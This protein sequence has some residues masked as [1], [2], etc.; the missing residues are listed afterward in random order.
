MK[1]SQLVAISSALLL[2]LA[3]C[4]STQ[5]PANSGASD[6][7][8]TQQTTQK[9]EEPSAVVAIKPSPDKYTWHMKNYVGMNASAVGHAS[10]GGQ[11][12]DRYGAGVIKIVFVTKDGT[13]IAIDDDEA[14]KQYK[15][16]AQSYE[17]NTEIKYTFQTNSEGE[18]YDSLVDFQ[19]I[20]E[21]VLS[22][23][24]VGENGNKADSTLIQIAPDKYA[25]YVRDYVGRN[26]S[27]CGY[28][29]LGGSIVDSY[30]AGYVT[31][32]LI[33]DDGA[34]IDLDDANSIARYK[35]TGQDVAPNSAIT[36]EFLKDSDGNEYSNLVDH[37][38]IQ[39]ISL[40]LTPVDA[41]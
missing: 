22:V 35:V 24:K 34:A 33:P 21:I 32:S 10:L 1:K 17:P 13:H 11:R 12:M 29:S 4:G 16:S 37:Q 28:V 23:D 26:L 15:V 25:A 9:S 31:F 3:G 8:A 19:N 20:E 2:A 36:F 7:S 18:E 38:S 14:L 41:A 30:S 39:T 6:S 40:Y 5:P 27:D